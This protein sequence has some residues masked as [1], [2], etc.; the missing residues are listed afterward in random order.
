MEVART[1]KEKYGYVAKDLVKEFK[2]FD[3]KKKTDSGYTLS[4]KFK[5]YVHKPSK[6]GKPVEIT[7][8]YERF[9]GPE[10]FFHPEFI[11]QDFKT[12][13]DE[14]IDISIQACPIDYRRKLYNN[15]VLSGGSTLYDGFTEKL[16]KLVKKR[17]D[18]R[19]AA[20]K[21]VTGHTTQNI[22]TVEV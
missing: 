13:L 11:N 5:N 20:Y 21:A 1:C 10:M 4:N 14:V 17:V 19:F 6:G 8:G 18:D 9:L 2:K 22:P 16:G 7:V 15:I 12:P 3:E